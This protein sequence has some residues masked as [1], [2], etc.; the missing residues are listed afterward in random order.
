MTGP[1]PEEIR[2]AGEV[3]DVLDPGTDHGISLGVV[4][5]LVAYVTV[6]ALAAVFAFAGW[7]PAAVSGLAAAAVLVTRLAWLA[8]KS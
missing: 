4:V 6:A 5:L 1:S 8:V 7:W 3:P 2:G